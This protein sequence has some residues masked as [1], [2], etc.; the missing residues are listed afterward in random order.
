MSAWRSV[1]FGATSIL[2][3]LF[4]VDPVR[5]IPPVHPARFYIELYGSPMKTSLSNRLNPAFT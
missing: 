2:A 1:R 4:I 3:T 5:L